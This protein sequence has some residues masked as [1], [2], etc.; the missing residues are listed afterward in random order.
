MAAGPVI[1]L[2]TD[3]GLRDPYVAAMKGVILGIAPQATIVDLSHEIEPQD[4][5]EGALALAAAWSYF[6]PG[7]VH[8]AVVDPGVGT[9][10][11]AVAIHFEQGWFVGPDNGI[12]YPSLL[13]QRAV[14]RD[15][16]T[17]HVL[18]GELTNERY[19]RIPVS[20]TFH[21]RDIFAPAAAHLLRG[22]RL[23]DFGPQV[24]Q[25]TTTLLP[26]LVR[27]GDTLQGSIVHI[28]RF[29]NA[30]TNLTPSDLPDSPRIIAGDAILYGL[31]PDYQADV[32]VALEGSTGFVEIAARNASAAG[33][34]DLHVGDRIIVRGGA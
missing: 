22:A 34:L 15:N 17:L 12:F 13:A 18:A 26:S 21:G 4:V 19:Q 28:D 14:E 6:P 10:R 2:T 27:R 31:A 7:T 11:R 25:I 9:A 24:A 3:F 23:E 33:Q 20:G 16:G 30:I 29:G 32:L 1:T 5:R 8:V